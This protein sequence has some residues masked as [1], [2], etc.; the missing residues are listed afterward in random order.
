MENAAGWISL[1]YPW[2]KALHLAAVISWMTALFY[3]PRLFAYHCEA[4]PGSSAS[5]TLEVMER[6][7]ARALMSPAM[8]VSVT[9]GLA[10]IAI[11]PELLRAGFMLA[12]L[13]MVFL[14]LGLH[15]HMLRWHREL[16]EGR[17]RHPRRFYRAMSEVSAALMVMIVIMII[18]RPF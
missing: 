16:V 17:N 11:N 14:V 8:M 18:V 2:I 5:E 10:M 9:A 7:L 6:R 4:E 3:L 1:S 13:F 12:K 15:A